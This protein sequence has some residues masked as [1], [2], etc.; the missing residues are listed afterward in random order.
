MKFIEIW[1]RVL[2]DVTILLLAFWFLPGHALLLQPLFSLLAPTQAFPPFWAAVTV[3]VL[4]CS[5][6]PQDCEHFDHSPQE[7]YLQSVGHMP[8]VFLQIRFEYQQLSNLQYL[9]SSLHSAK[10]YKGLENN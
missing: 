8:H 1:Y 4:S 3:L 9:L 7:E 2:Q 5:P 10:R 6:P